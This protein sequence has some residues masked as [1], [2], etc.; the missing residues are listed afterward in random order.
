MIYDALRMKVTKKMFNA[1]VLPLNIF[2]VTFT[3][4]PS[5]TRLIYSVGLVYT[6]SHTIKYESRH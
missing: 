1:G 6:K 3:P 2:F 5:Y 4:T